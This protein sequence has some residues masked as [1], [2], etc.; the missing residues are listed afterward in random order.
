MPA[1]W[2]PKQPRPEHL[3]PDCVCLGVTEFR[4][5]RRMPRSGW[6]GPARGSTTGV[7]EYA[8]GAPAEH[9]IFQ[10]SYLTA[11]PYP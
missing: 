2:P 10:D 1:T 11:R 8:P 7:P 9:L 6:L 3:G 5:L 4:H